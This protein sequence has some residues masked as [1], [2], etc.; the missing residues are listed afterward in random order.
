M[1][2]EKPAIYIQTYRVGT[3]L[4]THVRKKNDRS[5]LPLPPGNAWEHTP[6]KGVLYH[7][8]YASTQPLKHGG[9]FLEFWGGSG[10]LDFFLRSLHHKV[11]LCAASWRD[12]Y[13]WNLYIRQIKSK[14]RLQKYRLFM[15]KFEMLVSPIR[16]GF[17]SLFG[18][19]GN[20]QWW[21]LDKSL[22]PRTY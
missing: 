3:Q 8:V 10:P 9:A 17:P 6:H 14:T 15:N 22:N 11:Q 16:S 7:F 4:K 5:S 18:K 12:P 20:L 19:N 13:K 2:C 1:S 21:T